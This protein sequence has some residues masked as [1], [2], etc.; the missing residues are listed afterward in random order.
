MKSVSKKQVVNTLKK[1]NGQ[2]TV[3]KV[4]QTFK[5]AVK[6]I[7]DP[8]TRE[9]A[10]DDPLVELLF[11]SLAAVICGSTS[12]Y[13]FETF[14]N[15]Q[16]QWLK[17]VFPFKNGIPAHDTFRRVVE[18][19]EPKSL[20][21]AYRLVI[22]NLKIR[23]TKHIA[24]DGKTSRGCYSI[25]GQWLLHVVSAWDTEN[26]ISL[27]Q[28]ATK[29]DEGKD[30]G[31]YNTIPKLIESLDIG[32]ALV[33]IDAGGCY[34]EIVDAVVEGKG[35]YL[36]TLKDNQPTLL[37]ETKEIF[38]ELE[39]K[40]FAGVE[41]YRESSRGHGRIEE[42]TYYATPLPS[43]SPARKKWKNLKT[44]VMGI[45]DRTVKGKTSREVRYLISDLTSDQ[46]ARLGCSARAHWGIENKLHWVLDV[47]LGEDANRTR[48]GHGAENLSKLRRLAVGLMRKVK[49][50]QT[51][52]NMM[53]QAALDS[54]FRT[55]V[56]EKIVKEI[57]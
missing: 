42:R 6:E 30:V 7:D 55:K 29:N 14:G 47:S 23:T 3:K 17:K 13:D 21:K 22:E 52:P 48:R 50:K 25:K 20:E 28:I 15:A 27:G 9:G 33:T 32:D 12:Y 46:V 39:S 18:L 40:E 1:D 53:F 37:N 10:I 11:T 34:T 5:Q 4:V 45:F 24:I 56:V 36:V 44:L 31:E 8:R 2:R 38:S 26:D 16:L 35:H 43:E 54:D 19:L 51:V 57:P 41:W 49:G